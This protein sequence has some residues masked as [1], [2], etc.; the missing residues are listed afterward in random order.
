MP[1]DTTT[2]PVLDTIETFPQTISK[3]AD[4]KTTTVI[5]RGDWKD[6]A[7]IAKRLK[8]ATTGKNNSS[9]A[10]SLIQG[11]NADNEYIAG[12]VATRQ[13]G[14]LGTLQVTFSARDEIET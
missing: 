5:Y 6:L 4:L 1:D 12:V 7:D 10:G 2:T 8:V 3:Q 9:S 13:Q 14:G 11:F